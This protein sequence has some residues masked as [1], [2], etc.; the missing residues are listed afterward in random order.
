M[1]SP[2][3]KQ[4][5]SSEIAQIVDSL[6]SLEYLV[7][8]MG[9][10]AS[11]EGNRNGDSF[12][13]FGQLIEEVLKSAGF[14]VSIKDSIQDDNFR[15]F[16]NHVKQQGNPSR[17][18]RKYLEGNP[19]AAHY[20]LAALSKALIND[21]SVKTIFLTTNYD[22][23]VEKSLEEIGANPKTLSLQ[24]DSSKDEAIFD[25]ALSALDQ[26]RPVVM[27]LLGD[28][29]EVPPALYQD[30]IDCLSN[31]SEEILRDWM[32][33]RMLVIGYSFQDDQIKQLLSSS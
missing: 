4:K 22:E 15:K 17:Y 2:K 16:I 23:L 20:H 24:F 1:G 9:A 31:K 28:L 8:F 11:M 21:F 13:S 5:I 3:V 14:E 6:D 27:H 30:E 18:L 29:K 32:S 12:P 26:G 33:N 19:G 10:G 25:I 7:I